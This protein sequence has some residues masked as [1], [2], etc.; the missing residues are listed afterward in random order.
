[1]VYPAK[2]AEQ[3]PSLCRGKGAMLWHPRLAG[4]SAVIPMCLTSHCGVVTALS[5]SGEDNSLCVGQSVSHGIT[6]DKYS[7]G[8]SSAS[9]NAFCHGF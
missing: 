7:S 9:L 8:A 4:S 6:E 1:M 3:L 2:Q 5:W